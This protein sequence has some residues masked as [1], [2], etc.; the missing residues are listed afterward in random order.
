MLLYTPIVNAERNTIT[1]EGSGEEYGSF[2]NNGDYDGYIIKYDK[3]GKIIWKKHMEKM[4]RLI[5]IQ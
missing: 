4:L 5:L 2:E 3:Y 1:I